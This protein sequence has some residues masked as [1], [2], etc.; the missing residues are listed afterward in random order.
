MAK[1]KDFSNIVEESF[2]DGYI[3]E[4]EVATEA[5]EPEK[6]TEEAVAPAEETVEVAVE[7]QEPAV[8]ESPVEETTE[9]I[10]EE[11]TEDVAEE[12]KEEEKLTEN[13]I[14]LKRIVDGDEELL[15]ELWY[16]QERATYYLTGIQR[17]CIDIMAREEV[18]SKNAVVNAAYE[19]FFSDEIKE[20]AKEEVVRKAIK[21]LERKI[22]EEHKKAA[23]E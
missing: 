20:A 19:N 3:S 16:G 6:K 21:T 4:L 10:V 18:M 12:S 9:E 5:K 2:N 7:E 1:K 14:L 13:E 11:A 22:A 15:E 8:E 23:A 17:A